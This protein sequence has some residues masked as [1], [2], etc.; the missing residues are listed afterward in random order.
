MSRRSSPYGARAWRNRPASTVPGRA[1]NGWSVA[2][3]TAAE[4]RAV[5]QRFRPGS[6]GFRRAHGDELG[7]ERVVR[8]ELF[9]LQLLRCH[10]H[11]ERDARQ[12]VSMTVHLD[13]ALRKRV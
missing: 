2:R 1:A 8:V 10:T 6:A 5:D 3:S 4:H 11:Q 12:D 9:G 7:E 13:L